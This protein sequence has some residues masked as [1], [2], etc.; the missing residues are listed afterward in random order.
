MIG[1]ETWRLADLGAKHMLLK[2]GIGWGYEPT[3]VTKSPRAGW[4]TSICRR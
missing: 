3:C 4:F 2:A 1:A